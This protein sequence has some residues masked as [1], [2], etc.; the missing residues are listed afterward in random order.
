MTA[1][2]FPDQPTAYAAS[3]GDRLLA[4]L[5]D[6]L[7]FLV[8]FLALFFIVGRPETGPDGELVIHNLVLI[9][10]LFIVVSAVYEVTLT[11]RSGQTIGKRIRRIR[12]AHI[13]DGTVPGWGT[14]AVRWLVANAAQIL[15]L[16]IPVPGA[17]LY[18]LGDHVLGL[19][20]PLHLTLHD[21]AAKTVVVRVSG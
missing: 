3:I 20:K 9:T 16:A 8:P 12:V 18:T 6:G 10:A 17:P 7:I 2:P 14:S 19:R 11:A 1:S 5:L 21:I 4:R 15:S 13:E